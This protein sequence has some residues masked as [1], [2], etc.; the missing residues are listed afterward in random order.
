MGADPSTVSAGRLAPVS[1][2]V[3]TVRKAAPDPPLEG[4]MQFRPGDKPRNY[5]PSKLRLL[6]THPSPDGAMARLR[7]GRALAHHLTD[8]ERLTLAVASSRPSQHLVVTSQLDRED[9]TRQLRSLFK[10][11]TRHSGPFAYVAV[12]ADGHGDG[13][14]HAHILLWKYQH[15][16]PL[17]GFAKDL[18]LGGV[19]IKAVS[20]NRQSAL[21]VTSY[22][23]GQGSKVFLNDSDMNVTREKGK[24]RYLTP[25]RGTLEKLHPELLAALDLANDQ[26]LSDVGLAQALPYLDNSDP[27]RNRSKSPHRVTG[28]A[29][30]A[31]TNMIARSVHA[32]PSWPKAL[33]VGSELNIG[34]ALDEQTA[35][36]LNRGDP[37]DSR[38][39]LPGSV[40]DVE[41]RFCSASK[42]LRY[43]TT[44]VSYVLSEPRSS[45]AP[46]TVTPSTGS[47]L[48]GRI[49]HAFAFTESRSK[50]VMSEGA[51]TR[52]L[53]QYASRQG[54]QKAATNAHINARAPEATRPSTQHSKGVQAG[55]RIPGR[56][57]RPDP[58]RNRPGPHRSVS[59]VP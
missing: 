35:A 48:G 14:Y 37:A 53:D 5:D 42:I 59:G 16:P 34:A 9:F 10:R 25:Q 57:S 4:A 15:L 51:P 52:L 32:G 23:F 46:M 55:H 54:R 56:R 2:P 31:P 21:T 6:G 27:H 50:H 40:G 26:S 38:N 47:A 18:G 49:C 44:E 24:R 8:V 1:L 43:P 45:T 30:D 39:A 20:Q 28:A 12:T 58:P 33:L 13:G 7:A 36:R 41:P 11:I 29:E 19:K 22:V 3:L 17:I